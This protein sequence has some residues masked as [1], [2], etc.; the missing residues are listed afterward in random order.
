[1]GE[2][3]IPTSGGEATLH[4]VANDEK[5][6]LYH[7]D[8]QSVLAERPADSVDA[9][10]TDPPYGLRF[11]DTIKVWDQGTPC[12]PVWLAAFRALK[13]GGFCWLWVGRVPITVFGALSKTQDSR[14]GTRSAGST[15]PAS[16]SRWT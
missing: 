13:P 5:V 6:I 8:M 14:Y 3:G 10:V 15:A 9:I 4:W 1:M 7:G 16:R 12:I 2:L 11:M